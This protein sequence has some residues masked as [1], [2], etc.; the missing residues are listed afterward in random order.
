MAVTITD[1]IMSKWE[2]M[3]EMFDEHFGDVDIE[4]EVVT[5]MREMD[6]LIIANEFHGFVHPIVGDLRKFHKQ[7]YGV[8]E[9]EFIESAKTIIKT[10]LSRQN[11]TSQGATSGHLIDFA[12]QCLESKTAGFKQKRNLILYCLYWHDIIEELA[13]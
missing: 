10:Q 6:P 5:L 9:V 8:T 7:S 1:D 13:N 4:P 11:F 2:H 3:W 12:I